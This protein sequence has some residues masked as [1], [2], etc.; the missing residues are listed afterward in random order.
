M[1]S[2]ENGSPRRR[3]ELVATARWNSIFGACVAVASPITSLTEKADASISIPSAARKLVL[4]SSP[5][6]QEKTP[7]RRTRSAGM[8]T[9]CR[10]R[11]AFPAG[12]V[13]SCSSSST[14]I[15]MWSIRPNTLA[16]V[17]R[18]HRR[19][20]DQPFGAEHDR[21]RVGTVRVGSDLRAHFKS[22]GEML[23]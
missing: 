2:V 20:A 16:N 19:R 9:I 14:P 3:V 18:R 10:S 13:V 23:R 1:V 12:P 5:M 15:M 7:S 4:R 11:S 21:R 6:R 22:P 17:Q 8:T